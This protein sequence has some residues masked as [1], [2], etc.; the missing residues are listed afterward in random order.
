MNVITCEN[1]RKDYR[2]KKAND[3]I[4]FATRENTITGVI[5]RNGAGKTTLLKMLAGYSKPTSG[6]IT[7]YGENPFQN[8]YTAANTIFIDDQMVFPTSF[9]ITNIFHSCQLFYP[10]WDGELA[11]RLR[12]YFELPKKQTQRHLSKGQKSTLH[13]IVGL[14]ARCPVTIFDEPTTG[15]DSSVRKDFYRA[16][17]KDYIAHPRTILL[18]SHQVEEI[19]HLLEDVLLIDQG[20]VLLHADIDEVRAYGLSVVGDALTVKQV[21]KDCDLIYKESI[22]NNELR[23]IVKNDGTLDRNHPAVSIQQVPAHDI[24]IYLSKRDKGGIDHVFQ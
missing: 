22:G 3:E 23:I 15:M 11:E 21:T 1:V 2:F 16:L 6:E 17:L 4:T 5:G 7:I 14:A 13:M 8:T 9:S 24:V 20:K 19:E 12:A 10:N 18:S